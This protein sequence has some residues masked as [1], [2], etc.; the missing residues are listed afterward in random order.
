[1]TSNK[2]PLSPKE[3]QDLIARTKKGDRKA[4]GKLVEAYRERAFAG[5]LSLVQNYD[6]ARDLS[7]DAFVKAFRAMDR[8]QAGRPFYPWLYRIMRN[9]CLSFLKKYGPS[10]MTSLD[11]LVE[12][13]HVQ[14]ESRE[15][16]SREL[17]QKKQLAALLGEAMEDLKPEFR[18]IIAMK[19]FEEM[20]YEEIARALKIPPGTVMSRLYYARKALKQAMEAR[21]ISG[22]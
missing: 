16:D 15:V 3:E 4:Y 19:H 22:I 7:Q 12:E 13:D 2:S 6:D 5:A 10:R 14:F 9:Q 18:E 11:R 8:F 1:V 17:L 21:G 20:S